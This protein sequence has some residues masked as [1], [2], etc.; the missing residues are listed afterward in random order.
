M[1]LVPLE[2]PKL[3]ITISGRTA[4]YPKIL[5]KLRVLTLG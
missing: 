2:D 5:R 3:E 4:S 1:R